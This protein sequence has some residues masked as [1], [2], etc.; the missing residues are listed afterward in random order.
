MMV[1]VVPMELTKWVMVP[2]VWRQISGPVVV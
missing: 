1:P 2:W